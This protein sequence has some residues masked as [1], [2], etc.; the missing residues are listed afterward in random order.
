MLQEI[1][2]GQYIEKINQRN[3]INDSHNSN[4]SFDLIY[5]ENSLPISIEIIPHKAIIIHEVDVQ[6]RSQ[7]EYQNRECPNYI[8]WLLATSFCI[9][10]V[11]VLSSVRLTN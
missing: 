2:Y 6:T 11:I 10:I 9:P 1:P 8:K 3:N 7:P 4:N 5:S